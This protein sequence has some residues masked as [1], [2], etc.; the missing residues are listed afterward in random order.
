M[1]LYQL[2]AI[3]GLALIIFLLQGIKNSL[4]ALSGGLVYWLPTGLFLARVS[5]HAHA[6]AALRFFV[7]FLTGE[8]IK[9][10]LC[11][12]LFLFIVKYCYADLFYALMG[13]VGAI[14]AYWVSSVICLIHPG[15][16][17]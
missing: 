2:I 12:I 10:L 14:V 9:L 11:G 16:K 5:S 4:S 1:I 6:R 8:A 17:A 3:M 7:T 15:V 13:L